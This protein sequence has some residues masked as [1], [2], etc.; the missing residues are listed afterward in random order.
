MQDTAALA[1]SLPALARRAVVENTPLVESIINRR[2]TDVR[3]IDPM[4]ADYV[5]LGREMW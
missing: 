4:A 1:G 3:P 2:S 5:R